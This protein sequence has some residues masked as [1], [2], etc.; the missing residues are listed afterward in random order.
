MPFSSWLSIAI[1]VLALL[2]S[3]AVAYFTYRDREAVALTYAARGYRKPDD[4]PAAYRYNIQIKNEG[5][6]DAHECEIWATQDGSVQLSKTF[7]GALR[8]HGGQ[9]EQEVMCDREKPIEIFSKVKPPSGIGPRVFGATAVSAPSE[10]APDGPRSPVVK[11]RTANEATVVTAP[12]AIVGTR[13]AA[14]PMSRRH[15]LRGLPSQAAQCWRAVH[16]CVPRQLPRAHE[17]RS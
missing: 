1:S 7:L 16:L 11:N 5:G 3:G 4:G 17:V 15:A 6:R 12:E 9:I 13:S 8:R 2:V 14:K 10:L